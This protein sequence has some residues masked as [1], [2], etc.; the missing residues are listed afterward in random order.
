MSGGEEAGRS[1]GLLEKVASELD[2]EGLGGEQAV[3]GRKDVQRRG[4]S[5]AWRLVGVLVLPGV[6]GV[7]EVLGIQWGRWAVVRCRRAQ[8][9]GYRSWTSFSG[10]GC[11]CAPVHQT[12][13]EAQDIPTKPALGKLAT[14]LGD[15]QDHDTWCQSSPRK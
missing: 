15:R 1:K 11:D 4:K 10:Q 13:L 5:K 6:A 7:S 12:L 9:P 3:T 14:P 2:P 8:V